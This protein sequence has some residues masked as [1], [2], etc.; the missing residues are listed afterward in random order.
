MGAD[1]LMTAKEN[2]LL[3]ASLGYTPET[4]KG[5]EHLLLEASLSYKC[6][7]EREGTPS[8][9]GQPGLNMGPCC[10]NKQI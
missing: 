2:L 8:V 6:D 3:E 1:V 4:L 10:K 5:R 7:T 9:R